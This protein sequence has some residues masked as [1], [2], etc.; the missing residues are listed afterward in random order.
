M[1]NEDVTKSQMRRMQK[2]PSA[3][4]VVHRTYRVSLCYEFAWKNFRP[5][6][7]DLA[8][9]LRREADAAREGR[10]DASSSYM[11]SRSSEAS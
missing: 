5:G 1:N 7:K 2:Q 11:G 10:E 6:L 8:K 9:G 3:E 4:A